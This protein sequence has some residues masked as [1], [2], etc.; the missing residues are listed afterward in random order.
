MPKHFRLKGPSLEAIRDKAVARH[1]AGA[2]I[3]AAE[4]VSNPGIAGLFAGDRFEA[5][6]E[7]PDAV[8]STATPASVAAPASLAA[9]PAAGETAT[10][11]PGAA[12]DAH[13]VLRRTAIAAL[14]EEAD[15]S[16]RLLHTPR[17]G[18]SA[19]PALPPVNSPAA[20]E[21]TAVTPVSTAGADFA[22]LLAQLGSE[23]GQLPPAVVRSNDEPRAPK[24][25]KAHAPLTGAGDLVLLLGLGDDA[26]GPAL[27]ISMAAGGCDVRTGGRLTAFGHLHVADR[28]AATAARASAVNTGQTLLLAYGLGRPRDVA[29]QAALLD[30]IGADQV[31]AVVDARRKTED[32]AAW[33]AV[34]AGNVAVDALAVVGSED[35]LSPG[36]VE[37]LGLPVGWLD[38]RKVD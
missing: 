25:R 8:A 2:R 27:E 17:P 34:L 30:A 33:L 28:Q 37:G 22:G 38:G 14:L 9:G 11:V 12:A 1:G 4:K 32:T 36:T 5:T 23:Y 13:P 15:A 16:E 20:R 26:L 7:V 31:W 10:A 29:A 3:I 18:V 19:G 35:T 24:P 6:V 21:D